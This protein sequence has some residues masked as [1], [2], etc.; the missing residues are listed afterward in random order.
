MAA[1]VAF[2]AALSLFP[3]MLMLIA[4]V[5]YFFRFVERGR[6]AR[7]EILAT[8]SQQLSPQV[9]EAL[10]EML[11][12]VQSGALVTGP[13]AGVALVFT[14]SMVYLQIDRGFN[15]IW[16]VRQRPAPKGVAHALRR[17]IASRVRSLTMLLGTGLVVVIVF[18][19][20]LL[21]RAGN[22]I[23]REW[24]PASASI[25]GLG[26][27]LVGVAVNTLVFFMLYRYLS[28]EPV[29]WRL[30]LGTAL[31]V[32]LL[33]E[34]GRWALGAFSFG[35]GFSVYGVI[36]SFLLVQ[37]WIYYNAM[38]LFAG[39]VFVRTVTKPLAP[40]SPDGAVAGQGEGDA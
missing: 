16:Q 21:L 4:G 12:R 18:V 2:Y 35:Q 31:G 37:V 25:P 7:E 26:S 3:L 34:I 14:A 30:C 36:G 27:L 13:L 15:R 22:A 32:A 24:F 33:W 8:V 6:D 5:G 19:A 29:S 28:K 40:A 17:M 39:A 20:G 1:G 11:G 9:G 23:V 10:G 38:V